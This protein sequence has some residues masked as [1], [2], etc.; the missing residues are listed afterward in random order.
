[1][2]GQSVAPPPYYYENDCLAIFGYT[3]TDTIDGT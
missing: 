3:C 1:M 2:V